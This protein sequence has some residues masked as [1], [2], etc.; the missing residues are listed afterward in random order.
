MHPQPYQ[1]WV[2]SCRTCKSW[3]PERPATSIDKWTQQRRE[4]A[5]SLSLEMVV[6]KM[7]EIFFFMNIIKFHYVLPKFKIRSYKLVT[8]S[9]IDRKV[10]NTLQEQER[11]LDYPDIPLEILK[12]DIAQ[13]KHLYLFLSWKNCISS[14]FP[15]QKLKMTSIK[16]SGQMKV[17]RKIPNQKRKKKRKNYAMK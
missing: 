9:K 2:Q 3:S 8:Y 7:K 17:E 13:L 14:C 16:V 15:K 5:W 10:K 6:R 1:P 11:V 4:E 12:R